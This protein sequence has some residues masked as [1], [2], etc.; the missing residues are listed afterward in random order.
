MV[1]IVAGILSAKVRAVLLGP[2]GVGVMALLQTTLGL[3]VLVFGIGLGAGLIR[4]LSPFADRREHAAASAV[5]AAAWHIRLVSILLGLGAVAIFSVP[6]AQVVLGNADP[7]H[8]ILLIAGAL[9]LALVID[10]QVSIL[11]S[12]HQIR[13]LSRYSLW[14]SLAG[15]AASLTVLWIWRSDG[16]APA[17]V[18]TALVSVAMSTY[19]VRTSIPRHG[20]YDPTS[21]AGAR[22][23]L[24][25]FCGPYSASQLVGTGVTLGMPILVLHLLGTSNVA[26]FQA[27]AV[28]AGTYLGFLMTAMSQDYY[29]RI[30]AARDDNNLL[31]SSINRQIRL[32]LIVSLPL[33]FGLFAI[34]PYL[35]PL[36]YTSAFRPAV[37]VLEWQLMADLFKFL[38]WVFAFVIL[39]RTAGLTYFAVELFGGLAYLA[40]TWAGITVFGLPGAGMSWLVTYVAYFLLVWL[41]VRRQTGFAWS[42]QNLIT[43]AAA[44]AGLILL[45]LTSLLPDLRLVIALALAVIAL[46]ASLHALRQ[47]SGWPILPTDWATWRKQRH[48]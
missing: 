45:R 44:I 21:V 1:A 16:I 28:V 10:L 13:A 42:R 29:P 48:S 8:R 38:S 20:P 7:M 30:S 4:D 36:I 25:G 23:S 17:I 19:L 34:A 41:V 40:S 22:G 14:T 43:I 18:V 2:E 32:V 27:A 11:T 39:A 33:I 15:S 47:E 26:F 12:Y 46:A 5:I 3:A 31:N 6:L 35:I 24:L 9:A 37:A